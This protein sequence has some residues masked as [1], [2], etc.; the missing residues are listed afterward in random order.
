MVVRAFLGVAEG[1]LLPGIV[2]ASSL[3]FDA[4]LNLFGN[5]CYICLG[6]T[7]GQRWLLESGFSILPLLSAALS[8]VRA[9]TRDDTSN[10]S[11]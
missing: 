6:C 7:Q 5:R 3:C 9:G 10:W 8:E 2:S 1:G 4:E 11:N